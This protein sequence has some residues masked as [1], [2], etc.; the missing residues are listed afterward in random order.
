MQI[1]SANGKWKAIIA[2]SGN[3][4]I[5]PTKPRETKDPD[6][7]KQR[8]VAGMNSRPALEFNF[9]GNE[10]WNIDESA[11]AQR[12]NGQTYTKKLTSVLCSFGFDKID[13][14]TILAKAKTHKHSSAP[15]NY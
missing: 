15:M 10:T 3:V 5:W 12:Y 4:S 13:I 2:D 6:P 11:G 8:L 14:T 7:S 9:F 1:E